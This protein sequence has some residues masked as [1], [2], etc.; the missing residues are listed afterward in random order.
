[1]FVLQI[2]L[3]G[4]DQIRDEVIAAFELH[5]DLGEGVLETVPQGDEPVVDADDEESQH[6][7]EGEEGQEDD[8][9]DAHGVEG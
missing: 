5:I 3:G 4:F 6:G 2:A 7:D 8:E 9:D 1:M